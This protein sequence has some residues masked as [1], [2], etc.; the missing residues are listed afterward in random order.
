MLAVVSCSSGRPDQAAVEEVDAARQKALNARDI[1]QYLSLMSRSYQDGGKDYPA[2]KQELET[3]FAA[4]ERVSYRPLKR[5][6]TV[7]G[8]TATIAG[9]YMLKIALRGRTMEFPGKEEIRLK[10]E[11]SGWKI[12]GGL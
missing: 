1:N 10:K 12:V 5:T 8:N 7:Q 9:D 6:I 2:K 4:F 3:S 11:A